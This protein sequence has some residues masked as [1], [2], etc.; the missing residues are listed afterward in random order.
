MTHNNNLSKVVCV[1]ALG[2]GAVFAGVALKVQSDP[3]AFTTPKK[4]TNV[5]LEAKPLMAEKQAVTM[6]EER[7]INLEPLVIKASP[8]K[9]MGAAYPKPTAKKACKLTYRVIGYT[10]SKFDTFRGVYSCDPVE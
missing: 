10:D 7:V 1:L 6:E 9:N 3:F 2:L 5:T 8:R 4:V